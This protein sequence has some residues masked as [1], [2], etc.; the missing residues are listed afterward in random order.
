MDL[1]LKAYKASETKGFFPYERFDSP[2]KLD[3]TE[4]PPY[5]AFFSTLSR[6]ISTITKNWLMEDLINKVR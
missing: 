2:D 4:L 6:K 3:C 1:F 5:D